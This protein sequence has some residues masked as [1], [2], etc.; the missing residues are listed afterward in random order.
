M[1]ILFERDLA[2]VHLMESHIPMAVV[3]PCGLS[4]L[5]LT[6]VHFTLKQ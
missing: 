2:E 6:A 1:A 5:M 3:Q 4:H